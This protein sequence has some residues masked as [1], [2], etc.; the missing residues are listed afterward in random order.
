MTKQTKIIISL[1]LIALGVTCRLLPHLWNFAP[2]AG[3]ALFAG[4]YLGKRYAIVLPIVAMLVGDFFIGFYDWKLVLAVYLSFI[5]AGLIGTL[6][7]KYKSMETVLAGSIVSAVLFFLTTNFVVWQFSPWYAKSFSGLVQCYTMALPFFRNA[8]LGNL[9]YVAVLFG[10]Y[11]LVVV[12]SK[13]KKL[14]ES[15][16]ISN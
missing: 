12:F 13:Q 16:I 7:R 11:E 8:V 9:F 14:A 10:A 5:M 3:I 4:V 6:I 2:I 15:H 1:I